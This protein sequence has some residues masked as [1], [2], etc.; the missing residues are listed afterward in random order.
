M[1]TEN[2]AFENAKHIDETGNEYWS[3]CT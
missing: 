2:N 1:T 3:V